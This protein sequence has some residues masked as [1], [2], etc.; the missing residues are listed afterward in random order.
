MG[1]KDAEKMM[2]IQAYSIQIVKKVN[3]MIDQW[4]LK[5]LSV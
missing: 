4:V 3:F 1:I 5:E 2:M